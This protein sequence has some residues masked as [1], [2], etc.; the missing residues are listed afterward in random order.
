MVG[1]MKCEFRGFIEHITQRDGE[2]KSVIQQCTSCNDVKAYS[3]EVQK[4]MNVQTLNPGFQ[5][6]RTY[7]RPVLVAKILPFPTKK[8]P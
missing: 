5:P 8:K 1:C 4:R 3:Q 7:T 2:M 6:P